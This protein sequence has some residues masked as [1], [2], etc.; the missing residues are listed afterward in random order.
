MPAAT[1]YAAWMDSNDASLPRT[2]NSNSNDTCGVLSLFNTT[3]ARPRGMIVSPIAVSGSLPR[4]N[5]T[6]RPLSITLISCLGIDASKGRTCRR[7]KL[8]IGQVVRATYMSRMIGRGVEI[9][10]QGRHLF[11]LGQD[12][13]VPAAAGGLN[14]RPQNR[15]SVAKEARSL[16][17]D[18]H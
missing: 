4:I 16:A 3:K 12:G 10:E 6:A 5:R 18:V 8:G 2:L 9:D 15:T 11:G 14:C 7:S 1:L 17:A 13:D